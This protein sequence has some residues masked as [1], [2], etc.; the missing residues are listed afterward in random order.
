MINLIS[1]L[2]SL[3]P[4]WICFQTF[5]LRPENGFMMLLTPCLAAHFF[6]C[7]ESRSNK[8]AWQV[9]VRPWERWL[10]K[11]PTNACGFVILLARR[12]FDQDFWKE[13]TIQPLWSEPR[14][15]WLQFSAMQILISGLVL[16]DLC[17][18]MRLETELLK[19]QH[20]KFLVQLWSS[21]PLYAIG[22]TSFQLIRKW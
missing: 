17:G 4:R 14:H 18:E 20:V 8:I 7:L 12:F 5:A 11:K 9:L 1:F 3:P 21:A 10:F 16:P 19:L 6:T 15:V 2:V 13:I 22:M